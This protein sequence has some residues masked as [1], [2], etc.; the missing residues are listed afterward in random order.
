MEIYDQRSKRRTCLAFLVYLLSLLSPVKLF[1][2]LGVEDVWGR[3]KFARGA[4]AG[5][6]GA[7]F[8]ACSP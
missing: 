7:L 6:K 4:V 2:D 3:L 1:L 5:P 8:A